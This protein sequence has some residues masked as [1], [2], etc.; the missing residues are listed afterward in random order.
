MPY[1]YRF[2]VPVVWETEYEMSEHLPILQTE[3]AIMDW[4]AGH[5]ALATQL[6]QLNIPIEKFRWQREIADNKLIIKGK[7]TVQCILKPITEKENGME[8]VLPEYED[9]CLYVKV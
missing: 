5:E 8:Y 1:R 3:E 9:T 4:V 2:N 6:L 7:T